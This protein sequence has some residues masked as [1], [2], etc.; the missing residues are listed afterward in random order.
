MLDRIWWAWWS[1]VERIANMNT[2]QVWAVCST[3]LLIAG[4]QY[5]LVRGRKIRVFGGIDL[6]SD[7]GWAQLKNAVRTMALALFP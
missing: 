3:I 2:A 1:L 5:L 7:A 6:Q 4:V